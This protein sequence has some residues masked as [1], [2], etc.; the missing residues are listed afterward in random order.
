MVFVLPERPNHLRQG[1]QER[2][3]NRGQILKKG[4]FLSARSNRQALGQLGQQ[5][6][7]PLRV[8][9]PRRLAQR[10]ERGAL[11]AERFADAAQVAG[12]LQRAQAG[13]RG[14]EETQQQ[15]GNVLIEK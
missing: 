12:F 10:A 15:Q 2:A 14:I 5:R 4:L 3:I 9:N 13:K 1:R 11:A 8:E 7:Q 6:L